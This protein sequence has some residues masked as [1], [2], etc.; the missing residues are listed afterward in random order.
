MVST[1]SAVSVFRAGAGRD[2]V[3]VTAVPSPV[4]ATFHV[5]LYMCGHVWSATC[6]VAFHWGSMQGSDHGR[7]SHSATCILGKGV[8]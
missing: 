6:L 5:C 7:V 2:W 3:L 1:V 4:P 8:R